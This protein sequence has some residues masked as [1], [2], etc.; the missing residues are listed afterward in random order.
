MLVL[1]Q[2]SCDIV[3]RV[4]LCDQF[5]GHHHGHHLL[6]V[7]ELNLIPYLSVSLVAPQWV[8]LADNLDQLLG[9]WHR[10]I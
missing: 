4:G 10:A 7:L 3:A 2:D 5:G 9:R 8:T 6:L 1:D